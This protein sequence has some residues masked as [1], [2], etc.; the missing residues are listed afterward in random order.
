MEAFSYGKPYATSFRSGSFERSKL[1]CVCGTVCETVC[2]TVDPDPDP[3][4]DPDP[5]PDPDP[6]AGKRFR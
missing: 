5:D 4:T 1:F 3:N 6:G 2:E